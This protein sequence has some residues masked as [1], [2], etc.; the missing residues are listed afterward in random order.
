MQTIYQF[1]PNYIKTLLR[2]SEKKLT[3]TACPTERKNLQEE[4]E[5]FRNFL[6][7]NYEGLALSTPPL[8]KDLTKAKNQIL[9]RLKKEYKALGEDTINWLLKLETEKL[10]QGYTTTDQTQLDLPSQVLLTEE[11]YKRISPILY[12]QIKK[13]LRPELGKLQETQLESS[14]YCHHVLV[15]DE[16]LLII[17]PTESPSILNHE[18][19]HAG[20]ILLKYLSGYYLQELG[21]M[22]ME[23][24]F[25]E[26]LYEQQGFLREDDYAHRFKNLDEYL[27]DATSYLRLINLFKTRNFS[28]STEDFVKII[29]DYE[30]LSEEQV[31]PYIYEHCLGEDEQESIMYILSILRSMELYD[32]S[33]SFEGDHLKLLK[34]D[35]SN[36]NSR[37]Q[38]PKEGIKVYKKYISKMQTMTK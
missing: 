33:S 28:A 2:K 31:L 17:N 22:Y 5:L 29:S 8:P 18:V 3:R 7:G 1:D 21:P 36:P 23:H 30:M 4:I 15:T 12:K 25:L 20:E 14:S 16:P 6:Q 34:P 10:F 38:P 9:S 19:E 35:I 13:L 27:D 32:V 11:N 24:H 26:R 37:F